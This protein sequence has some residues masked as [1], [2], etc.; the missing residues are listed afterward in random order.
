MTSNAAIIAH[1]GSQLGVPVNVLNPF[2]HPHAF[3][4]SLTIPDLP[5]EKESYVPAIGIGLSSNELTPNF[6]FTYRHREKRNRARQFESAF[7]PPASA[8]WRCCCAASY[9]RNVTYPHEPPR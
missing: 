8:F 2:P 7:R 1:I 4:Q 5:A 6:L 3:T 9:G